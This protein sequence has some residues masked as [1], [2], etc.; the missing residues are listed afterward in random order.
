MKFNQFIELKTF[1]SQIQYFDFNS[2]LNVNSCIECRIFSLEKHDVTDVLKNISTKNIQSLELSAVIR[3]PEIQLPKLEKLILHHKTLLPPLLFSQLKVL[4]LC[5]TDAFYGYPL[6]N[7]I[8]VNVEELVLH[9]SPEYE[10]KFHICFPKLIK[11]TIYNVVL[12]YNE[13]ISLNLCENLRYLDIAGVSFHCNFESFRFVSALN[14]F[15]APLY[16]IHQVY[17][18]ISRWTDVKINDIDISLNVNFL[19][20]S[21]INVKG[22][23]LIK[24]HSDYFYIVGS[25]L[26]IHSIESLTLPVVFH[27]DLK[28]DTVKKIKKITLSI[29]DA[30]M[31]PNL[32]NVECICDEDG[33][34]DDF[35]IESDL[36]LLPK[37][38]SL[39]TTQK[40]MLL[41]N[42]NCYLL[43]FERRIY[44]KN[45]RIN[46]SLSFLCCLFCQK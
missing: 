44:V 20:K 36:L 27:S 15:A 5:H 35:I 29:F 28:S 9:Q 34:I 32:E 30:R 2:E 22:I 10:I 14:Y 8:F 26:K 19:D 3:W 39:I 38:N 31:F 45:N 42:W 4:H 33:N 1:D 46:Q 23:N 7:K 6:L 37:F 43:D 11:L 24:T 18:Y 21:K 41:K 12:Y 17:C 40:S 25:L 13:V 16:L